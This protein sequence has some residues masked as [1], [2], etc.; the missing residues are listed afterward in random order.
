MDSNI[1]ILLQEQTVLDL[2]RGF[3][4]FIT[5][6]TRVY[7]ELPN[8]VPNGLIIVELT[9]SG[10][11]ISYKDERMF[12]SGNIMPESLCDIYRKTSKAV[13]KSCKAI[14]KNTQVLCSG[15]AVIHGYCVLHYRQ[16]S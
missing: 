3:S 10:L 9:S 16:F 5:H 12:I 7:N 11:D 15:R 2:V 4:I 14:T 13:C 1:Y 6:R 8:L